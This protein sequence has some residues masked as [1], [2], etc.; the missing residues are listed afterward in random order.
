[1]RMASFSALKM[2]I[3]YFPHYI[4]FVFHFMLVDHFYLFHLPR[5]RF[6]W[7][8][9][10]PSVVLTGDHGC[11]DDGADVYLVLSYAPHYHHHIHHQMVL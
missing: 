10:S 8:L 3:R 9:V 4:F 5:P 7:T 6:I 1:M 2:M 11:D